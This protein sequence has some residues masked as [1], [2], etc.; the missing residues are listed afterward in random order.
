MSLQRKTE[1]T[2]SDIIDA[3]LESSLKT[4]SLRTFLEIIETEWFMWEERNGGINPVV[5]DLAKLVEFIKS[6]LNPLI[7]CAYF[8]ESDD[9]PQSMF[10][11]FIESELSHETHSHILIHAGYR[12]IHQSLEIMA[13]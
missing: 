10:K 13:H 7:A 6:R 4:E 3:L 12:S 5:S 2:I 9:T 1:Y 8:E 11:R